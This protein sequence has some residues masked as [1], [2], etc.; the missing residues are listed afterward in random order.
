MRKIW[1]AA[2]FLVILAA[3]CSPTLSTPPPGVLTLD[4]S[5]TSAAGTLTF[6]YPAAWAIQEVENQVLLSTRALADPNRSATAAPGQFAVSIAIYQATDLPGLNSNAT[7]RNVL[8]A[9]TAVLGDTNAPDPADLS[10]GSRRAARAESQAEAGQLLLIA[11]ELDAGL[12]AILVGSSAPGELA[13]FEPTL[14]AIAA[15]IQYSGAPETTAEVTEAM[16]N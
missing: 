5:Y 14:L 2:V 7:P 8:A 9:F 6:S 1:L 4:Q 15:T 11:L 3:A 16:G 12:Y 10:I 13:R